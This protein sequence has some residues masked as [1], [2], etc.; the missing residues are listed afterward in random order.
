MASD[1]LLRS[2]SIVGEAFYVVAEAANAFEKRHARLLDA[3][4]AKQLPLVVGTIYNPRFS[5]PIQ[6]VVC[7]GFVPFQR[8][9]H[10]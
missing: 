1:V 4:V 5:D 9:H 7:G 6:Q 3:C 2:V 10:P 8:C